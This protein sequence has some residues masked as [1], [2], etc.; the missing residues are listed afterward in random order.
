[1]NAA[2]RMVGCTLKGIGVMAAPSDLQQSVIYPEGGRHEH[3]A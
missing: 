2:L 3:T 1:M